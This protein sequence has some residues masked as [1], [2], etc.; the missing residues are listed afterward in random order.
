META[1]DKEANVD[2]FIV[3]DD[4]KIKW[5]STL[6]RHLVSGHIAQ[7]AESKLRQTVY[8]PFTKTELFFDKILIDR[9]SLFPSIFPTPETESEN[10]VICVSGIGSSKPFH[11]LV[12]KAIP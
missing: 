2:E 8:R 7:F 11:A 12:S 4:T 5:S 10:R 1:E 3:Y 6:K 9:S